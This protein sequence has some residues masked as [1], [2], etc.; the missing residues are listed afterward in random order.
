LPIEAK[1]DQLQSLSG[2]S[3]YYLFNSSEMKIKNTTIE[4]SLPADVFVKIDNQVV[5]VHSISDK[6]LDVEINGGTHIKLNNVEVDSQIKINPG[7][8]VNI[9]VK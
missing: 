1:G 8:I 6:N 4:F 7:D 3:E 9:E 5:T 2:N